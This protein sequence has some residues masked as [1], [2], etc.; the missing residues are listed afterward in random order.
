MVRTVWREVKTLDVAE[1]WNNLFLMFIMNFSAWLYNIFPFD[2]LMVAQEVE[3][4]LA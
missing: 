3:Q 2:D 4:L 1:K